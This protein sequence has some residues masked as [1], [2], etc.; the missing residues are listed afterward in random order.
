MFMWFC[1]NWPKTS[2]ITESLLKTSYGVPECKVDG[3]TQPAEE[4]QQHVQLI[5]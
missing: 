2:V 5:D 1:E 3:I 4:G